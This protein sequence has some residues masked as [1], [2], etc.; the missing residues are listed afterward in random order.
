MLNVVMLSVVMLSV[1]MLSVV[2]L[3]VIMLSVVMLIVMS[4]MMQPVIK[5][6]F[7]IWFWVTKGLLLEITMHRCYK[8][9][10]Q[11]CSLGNSVSSKTFNLLASVYYSTHTFPMMPKFTG[12]Q[13]ARDQSYK[14]FYDHNLRIFIKR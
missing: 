2:M 4:P 14:T 5:I 13:P 10:L 6:F 9:H 1:V 11:P 12:L 8:Y 7:T 3:S